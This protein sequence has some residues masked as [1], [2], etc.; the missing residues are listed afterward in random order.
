MVKIR[1]C[2]YSFFII[3]V[4]GMRGNST[5]DCLI[6]SDTP[7]HGPLA[8]A[9]RY[10]SQRSVNAWH[11]AILKASPKF[12][13]RKHPQIVGLAH[14]TKCTNCSTSI[15]CVNVILLWKNRPDAVD[16]RLDSVIL[17]QSHHFKILN[18]SIGWI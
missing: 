16:R 17:S 2:L 6:V 1:R 8:T 13:I 3:A 15:F 7:A 14:R 5:P 10:K 12:T 18:Y 4:R 9:Y 11:I